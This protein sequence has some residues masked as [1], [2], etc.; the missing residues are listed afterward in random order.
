MPY[1]GG[2]LMYT[3]LVK[4]Q[5]RTQVSE[6]IYHRESA[7]LKLLFYFVDAENL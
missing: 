1:I 7:N 3:L 2:F 6:L 5:M 4:R